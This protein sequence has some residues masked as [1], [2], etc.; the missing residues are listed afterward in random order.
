ML[1]KLT[2][3]LS[4]NRCMNLYDLARKQGTDMTSVWRRI[5][6]SLRQPVTTIP[7]KIMPGQGAGE[8]GARSSNAGG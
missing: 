1:T 3:E 5:C 8:S 7:A 4:T 6:R 2:M